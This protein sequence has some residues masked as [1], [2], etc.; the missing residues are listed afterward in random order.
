MSQE[1]GAFTIPTLLYL[2]P[3]HRARL[4]YLVREQETDL[5][6]LIS[7]IVASYLETQP[8][9]TPAPPDPPPDKA[10]ELRQRRVELARLRAQQS[11]AGPRAPAWLAAYIA[12]L[13][14]GIQRFEE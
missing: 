6:E 8:D 12:E 3:T 1:H 9:P 4:E 5:A 14:A 10:A 2:S 13:E 11:A 7:Q